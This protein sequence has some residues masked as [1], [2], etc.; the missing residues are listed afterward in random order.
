MQGE[1]MY[2]HCIKIGIVLLF[3]SA[4]FCTDIAE[5]EDPSKP[6]SHQE[7]SPQKMPS[8]GEVISCWDAFIKASFTVDD[9][10]I[11]T[12]KHYRKEK[13]FQRSLQEV[14]FQIFSGISLSILGH[15]SFI[16][17]IVDELGIIKTDLP[18]VSR[19]KIFKEIRNETTKGKVMLEILRLAALSKDIIFLEKFGTSL[20]HDNLQEL[21]A[22]N[23]K[24][25][26]QRCG[27]SCVE[28]C[29]DNIAATR[30]KQKQLFEALVNDNG[31]AVNE[32][33]KEPLPSNAS[34]FDQDLA[35]FSQEA[36]YKK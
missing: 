20:L 9:N 16:N 21:Q 30:K 22:T 33:C 2:K 27:E 23:P 28:E 19:K 1:S 17:D 14:R 6:E 10:N 11:A 7:T 12:F 34:T 26:N 15:V 5:P 35:W 36:V 3:S 31:K 4:I 25:F 13:I 8:P 32:I 24:K 18:I 29:T